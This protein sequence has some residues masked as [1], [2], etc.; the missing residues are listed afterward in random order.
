MQRS[1]LLL[2]IAYLLVTLS[3]AQAW[4]HRI[5][6]GRRHINAHSVHAL[7]IGDFVVGVSSVVKRVRGGTGKTVWAK[8][9]SKA[10]GDFLATAVD[11]TGV[12][13]IIGHGPLLYI[14]EPQTFVLKMNA[15]GKLAWKQ[16]VVSPSGGVDSRPRQVAHADAA[17]NVAFSMTRDGG[18]G[19]SALVKLDGVTGSEM[20]RWDTSLTMVETA[21]DWNSD[22][23]VAA[24]S[25]VSGLIAKVSGSSGTETWQYPI[26]D[27]IQAITV[28]GSN[29]VLVASGEYPLKGQAVTKLDPDGNLVWLV[30][31]YGPT[32]I[33]DIADDG[34]GNA[35]IA[36]FV[37]VGLGVVKLDAATGTEI[38]RGSTPGSLSN[39]EYARVT[40]DAAGNAIVTGGNGAY[41]PVSKFA[42]ADGSLLW[43]QAYT[44][45]VR[46]GSTVTSVGQAITSD[47]VGNV[48][49]ATS[50]R[51][52]RLD[53]TLN[54][55]VL[56]KR[57]GQ[58]GF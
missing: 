55:A 17:G 48:V 10:R 26:Y 57:D 22:L 44:I 58:T 49:S 12:T 14:S 21:Q 56:F 52:T 27:P 23:I 40:A 11:P 53:R 1:V 33:A 4:E 43:S 50:A 18:V 13:F 8:R 38:W 3:T 37:D 2:A 7:P 15:N 41:A 31:P 24:N 34:L 32:Y 42:A 19:P 28:D 46:P 45:P 54:M 29:N 6:G 51:S 36:G 20:W 9:I 16:S 25:G 47:T 30:S 5:R 35:L 39:L